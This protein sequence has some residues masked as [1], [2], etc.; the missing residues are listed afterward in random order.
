MSRDEAEQIQQIIEFNA[1]R[2]GP[3]LLKQ[4]LKNGTY[5]EFAYLQGLVFCAECGAKAITKTKYSKDGRTMYYYYACRHAR[6][7]CNNLKGTRKQQ[8]E[9]TL[10]KHFLEQSRTIVV[11]SD[12]LDRAPDYRTKRLEELESELSVLEKFDR[13]DPALEQLKETIRQQ[14]QDEM[15]P[16]SRRALERK[17][18][19]EIIQA[20]NNLAVWNLLTSD[21]KVDVIPKLLERITVAHGQVQSIV[22]KA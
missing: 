7:G 14:I 9:E 16:F 17:T 3:A 10:I 11:D 4:D 13:Q 1:S 5:A 22:L 19:Q 20:G 8:I 12:D 21:V 2:L 15:N 6:K 18:A